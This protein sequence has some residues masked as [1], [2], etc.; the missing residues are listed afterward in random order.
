MAETQSMSR[1]GT[2]PATGP[3]T[4]HQLRQHLQ[5][6]AEM[7]MAVLRATML[8]HG[9]LKRPLATLVAKQLLEVES[10]DDVGR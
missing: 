10:D 5:A 9:G 8:P 2:A 1:P 7:C 3:G 6:Q 4:G